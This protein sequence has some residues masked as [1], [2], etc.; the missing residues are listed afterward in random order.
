MIGY[1][2]RDD[3]EKV[4]RAN[5]EWGCGARFPWGDVMGDGARLERQGFTEYRDFTDSEADGWWLTQAGRDA[6]AQYDAASA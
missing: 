5:D 2:T 1:S 6:I 3:L 4:R